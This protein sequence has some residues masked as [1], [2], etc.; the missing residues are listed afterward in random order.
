M[1]CDEVL[2]P[3][4]D[5]AGEL[6]E[7]RFRIGVNPTVEIRFADRERLEQEGLGVPELG[8]RC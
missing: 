4:G 6:A 2:A 7:C 1:T 5:E 3:T 8:G